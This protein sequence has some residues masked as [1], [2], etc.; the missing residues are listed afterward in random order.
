MAFGRRHRTTKNEYCFFLFNNLYNTQ[1]TFF[2]W[3][4]EQ[5]IR[6]QV[7]YNNNNIMYL[8]NTRSGTIL[9]TIR[10]VSCIPTGHVSTLYTHYNIAL[11][12]CQIIKIVFVDYGL[13]HC[14][15]RLARAP[16]LQFNIILTQQISR[17]S[18]VLEIITKYLLVVCY[19][20]RR[21]IN[22]FNIMS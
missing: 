17:Y 11:R 18:G 4:N 5:N 2:A 12:C 6:V 15:Y 22:W 20:A 19:C 1:S 13:Y 9:Y 10:G 7:G 8:S 21:A 3:N 16:D 14:R